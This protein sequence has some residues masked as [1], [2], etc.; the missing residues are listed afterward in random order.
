MAV[1]AKAHEAV[2]GVGKE[3]MALVEAGKVDK[4]EVEE[5]VVVVKVHL[6][7]ERENQEPVVLQ[8][9]LLEVK[10]LLLH[11][12]AYRIGNTFR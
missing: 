9:P 10:M 11:D 5:V 12:A 6:E 4:E 8:R 2:D 1:E 3:R 7:L